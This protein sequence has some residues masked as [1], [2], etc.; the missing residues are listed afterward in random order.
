[1]SSCGSD[2]ASSDFECDSQQESCPLCKELFCSCENSP[3]QEPDEE[4]CKVCGLDMWCTC[5]AA[6]ERQVCSEPYDNEMHIEMQRAGVDINKSTTSELLAFFNEYY[7]RKRRDNTTRMKS[8]YESCLNFR[9]KG[10]QDCKATNP[11]E[12]CELNKDATF[13]CGCGGGLRKECIW[14]HGLRR[15]TCVSDVKVTSGESVGLWTD[16]ET[17]KSTM[18]IMY[19][20]LYFPGLV[21]VVV[22]FK[23][24]IGLSTPDETMHRDFVTTAM[25]AFYK[26]KTCFPICTWFPCKIDHKV[27][28]MN[29]F[30]LTIENSNVPVV[31][32]TCFRTLANV[33]CC[34]AI[35]CQPEHDV[36]LPSLC[37]PIFTV[38]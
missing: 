1:M 10:C 35:K 33:G 17:M 2:V 31:D 27:S 7:S 21:E 4:L 9:V 5:G 32:I 34:N 25:F 20:C 11:M 30:P 19:S 29:P 28:D 22:D 12:S 18:D 15:H 8:Y 16:I 24:V 23:K 13:K 37:K 26:E 6:R 3:Q 38:R 14:E 36:V